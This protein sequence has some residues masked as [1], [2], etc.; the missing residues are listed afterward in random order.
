MRELSLYPYHGSI[1]F[2]S[3][4]AEM[5]SVWERLTGDAYRYEDDPAGGRYFMIVNDDT[6]DVVW[7]VYA[8]EPGAIA[9]ELCHVLLHTFRAIGHD[10]TNGDGE[11]FCYLLS[12]LMRDALAYI[13]EEQTT[14]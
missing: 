2:F 5:R 12:A 10:P 7:L 1:Q 13:N 9:H 6:G 3:D 14:C 8:K 4:L 11:P